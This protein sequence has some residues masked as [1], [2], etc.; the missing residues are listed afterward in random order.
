MVISASDEYVMLCETQ[1]ALIRQGLGATLSVVY[2]TEDLADNAIAN[3]RPIV[4]MPEAVRDWSA[5]RL[6]TWLTESGHESGDLPRLALPSRGG[7]DGMSGPVLRLGTIGQDG[8]LPAPEPL[9]QP[10]HQVILPLGHNNVVLGALVV[11]RGDRPWQTAERTQVEHIAQ[12]L[13]IARLLDQR[14]QWMTQQFQRQRQIQTQQR[15][16]LGNLLHQ[17]RNPLTAMRTF[18]K[19][20]WRRL[21][22]EDKNR[23]LANS[24]VQ[25]SQRLEELLKQFDDVMDQGQALDWDDTDDSTGPWL[26]AGQLE[27]ARLPVQNALTGQQ[28]VLEGC[29]VTDVLAPLLPS[30]GAIAQDRQ[31]QLNVELADDLP[32]V[33][34]DRKALREVL[35]NLLDNA[36]KYTPAHE[37]VWVWVGD[38][39]G[40]PTGTLQAITIADTGPGIPP[41]DVEHIFERH[42]RGIQAHTDIPGTGLGLAIAQEL[43]TQMGGKLQVYSPLTAWHPQGDHVSPL[44]QAAQG[45]V[46]VVWLPEVAE[47]STP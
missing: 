31:I 11:A 8:D 41:E 45:T 35:N 27:P 29:A 20:L 1:M 2:L 42:Y 23:S 39:H 26:A 25:E 32:A 9:K 19:L 6:L 24:I 18:G 17:F 47:G 37:Q 15:E 40:T 28:L 3:L 36:L 21:L 7:I 5:E 34:A 12:T 38:R 30:A 46:L 16:M 10:A 44:P 22:P 4:A 13:A 14:S 43:V 33:I